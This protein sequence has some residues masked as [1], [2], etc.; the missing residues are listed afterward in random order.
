MDKYPAALHKA[1]MCA[2]EMY[3]RMA[4]HQPRTLQIRQTMRKLKVIINHMSMCT[5]AIAM[6]H[7][8]VRN[9]IKTGTHVG[10]TPMQLEHIACLRGSACRVNQRAPCNT[11]W[12][13]LAATDFYIALAVVGKV[14]LDFIK[15]SK[16]R[17][18]RIHR[19]IEHVA[20]KTDTQ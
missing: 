18:C 17:P 8:R 1:H 7:E 20:T 12:I 5:G 10:L 6:D 13:T 19:L 3:E 2:K 9:I 11:K 4:A 14:G 15:W 16:S